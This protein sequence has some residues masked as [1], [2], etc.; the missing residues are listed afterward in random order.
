MKERLFL[1]WAARKQSAPLPPEP[2]VHDAWEEGTTMLA[3]RCS[4]S[5]DITE[6]GLAVCAGGEPAGGG[7]S[8]ANELYDC[9]LKTWTA[10]ALMSPATTYGRGIVLNGVYHYV[11]GRAGLPTKAHHTYSVDDNV[12]GTKAS[13]SSFRINAVAAVWD[14]KIHVVG[15]YD[16]N[17]TTLKT[18]EV[19]DPTTDTW[20]AGAS[21]VYTR[22]QAGAAVLDGKLHVFGGYVY[23]GTNRKSHEAYDFTEG[24]WA[25]KAALETAKRNIVGAAGEGKVYAIAG[26]TTAIIAV[27]EAYDPVTDTWSAKTSIPVATTLNGCTAPSFQ[28][29]CYVFG[30]YGSDYLDTVQVYI[31]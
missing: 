26:Q 29:K 18:A 4:I 24:E 30:G 20:S 21:M 19:Y 16:G 13:L 12:W 27:V 9:T 15:G 14:G 3:P 25:T 23:S 6:E 5:A 1:M 2:E 22:T 10:K 11:G 31:P 7:R 28:K 17:T 8:T